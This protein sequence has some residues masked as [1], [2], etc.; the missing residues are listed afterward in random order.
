MLHLGIKVK[1][2]RDHL[3]ENGNRLI[4]TKDIHNIRQKMKKKERGN[5]SEEDI[6]LDELDNIGETFDIFI[7]NLENVF[8]DWPLSDRLDLHD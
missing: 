8:S 5:K 3:Q 2:L 4:S 6:L 7:I 1:F